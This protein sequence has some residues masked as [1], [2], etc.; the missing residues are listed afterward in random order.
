MQASMWGFYYIY[1]YTGCLRKTGILDS[2]VCQIFICCHRTLVKPFLPMP[3][4]ESWS[5][6][7]LFL[8]LLHTSN[9]LFLLGTENALGGHGSFAV[10]AVLFFLSQGRIK[11][12][13]LSAQSEQNL[14]FSWPDRNKTW[15]F[16]GQDRNKTWPF[17]GRI[18][19][20]HELF[21]AGKEHNMGFYFGWGHSGFHIKW[22]QKLIIGAP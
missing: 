16:L 20:K 11:Y 7:G 9:F 18:G 22:Y 1:I 6:D 21:S 17:L 5:S 19:T 4:A 12:E 10:Y 15:A 2:N 3:L 13:L 8:L 14:S